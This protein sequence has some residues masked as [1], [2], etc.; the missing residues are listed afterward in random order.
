MEKSVCSGEG[1]Y[2]AQTKS[3]RR[4]Q[5][6]G[7]VFT[8]DR[9]VSAMCDLLPP[10]MFEPERTFLE[11]CCGEGVFLL[12]ILRRKFANCKRRTDYSTALASVWG[13]DIQPDNVEITI[14][15][16]LSL[17]KEHFKPSKKDEETVEQHIIQCDS[18]KVMNLL[19]EYGRETR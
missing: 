4:V 6:F 19:E 11:P 2:M 12:E 1:P 14:R 8:S 10:E 18:L 13:M 9:E 3:K 16:I 7:E 5:E 17:S 15:N